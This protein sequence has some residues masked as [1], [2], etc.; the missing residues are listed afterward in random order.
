MPILAKEIDCY[1]EDLFEWQ[2]LGCETDRIWWALYTMARHEKELMRKLV[3]LGIPFYGPVIPKRTRSPG[4]RV[5]ESHVPLFPGY[6]FIYGDHSQ[7]YDAL[8]TNCV[9][10]Y[11]P[12][13]DGVQLTEQL[14]QFRRL[15]EMGVPLTPEERLQPGDLVRV[16]RGR[17]A[18]IEGVVVRREGRTRLLVA[19][20]F[21]RRG[22]TLVLEDCDFEV[23][24]YKSFESCRSKS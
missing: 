1:P 8:T 24:G 17:L 23:I 19:V 18:G 11:L 2:N 6:V 7:R 22:A 10:R 14:R 16:R 9:S 15:I 4:G 5:R 21:L 13:A 12:V 3:P 20:D